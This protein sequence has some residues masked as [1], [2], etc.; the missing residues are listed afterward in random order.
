MEK[1]K[2]FYD[3]TDLKD[4]YENPNVVG[5]TTNISF[6]RKAKITNYGSFIEESLKYAKGRPISFQLYDD[7]NE[8]I[9][10]TAKKISSYG[11]NIFV[12]IPVIKTNEESNAEVIKQLHEEGLQI[13]V[14]AIFTIQQVLSLKNCFNKTTPTIIS[15][16]AGRVNDSGMDCSELVKYACDLFK[17]YPNVEIL[18]AACR[19]VYNMFEAEKQGADIVTVPG[20]VIS[21]MN[22]IGDN[23]QEASVAQIK[24]FRQDGI[25]GNIK[26]IN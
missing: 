17:D 26:F 8:E 16:F 2:I 22:R 6:L 20:S 9:K 24:T 12:K 23:N 4:F 3:G 19:T 5:F 25:E 15:L 14:T 13:N 21:R 7:D 18:W 1:I 11:E 10:K